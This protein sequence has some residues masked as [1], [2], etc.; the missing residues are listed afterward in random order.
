MLAVQD[1]VELEP[2][3]PLWPTLESEVGR[4]NV[5]RPPEVFATTAKWSRALAMS[6]FLL[7]VTMRLVCLFFYPPHI[8]KVIQESKAE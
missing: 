4:S 8:K 2:H 6:V 1:E 3:C 7:D 5:M